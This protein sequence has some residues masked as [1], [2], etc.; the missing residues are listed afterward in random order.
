MHS[1][2]YR[3]SFQVA[4]AAVLGYLLLRI[5]RPLSGMLGWA[6]VLAFVLHP[7]AEWLAGRLNGRRALAAAILT[8]L[9]PF[10]VLAPEPGSFASRTT[11]STPC[12]ASSSAADSPA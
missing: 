4:T 5:L 12:F 7:L 8:G 3:R 6:V 9:T 1:D 10:L 2:F 11:A